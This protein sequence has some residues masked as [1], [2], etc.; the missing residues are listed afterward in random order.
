[1]R[2]NQEVSS[3]LKLHVLFELGMGIPTTGVRPSGAIGAG[4]GTEITGVVIAMASDWS[5][6]YHKHPILDISIR[7][8]QKNGAHTHVY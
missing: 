7:L 2:E 1:M 8:T 4:C 3:F 6:L 5:L